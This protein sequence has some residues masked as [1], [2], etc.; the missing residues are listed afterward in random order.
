M[1]LSTEVNIPL[2]LPSL[3]KCASKMGQN[4]SMFLIYEYF[5]VN[6]R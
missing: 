4:I 2:I 1:P 5:W 3:L 6:K